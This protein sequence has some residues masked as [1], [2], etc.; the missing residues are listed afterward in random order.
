MDS[1]GVTVR[2]DDSDLVLSLFSCCTICP[3]GGGGTSILTVAG[4]CRWTGY[5]FP[6]IT[7]DTG[8]LNQPNWLL[9]GY[10]VY[11]S[12]ASQPT[13]FMSG[14]RSRHRRRCVRDATYFYE[15]MMIHSR[16][17]SPSVP[18][19]TNLESTLDREL[20]PSHRVCIWKFLVRYIV[21]GCIFCAPSGLRQGQV[22][23]PPQRHVPAT[24]NMEVP[25]SPPGICLKIVD[26]EGYYVDSILYWRNSWKWVATSQWTSHI[27]WSNWGGGSSG[28]RTHCHNESLS[29]W[30]LKINC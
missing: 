6:V 29:Y 12:V 8:Y 9:A 27:S 26:K 21:T 2:S 23:H 15:C 30:I 10:S 20:S 14:P 17:E 11:H 5:D 22:F 13:M 1:V 25:P 16:I 24:V 18:V 4:T 28:F 19:P 7:I 3:G